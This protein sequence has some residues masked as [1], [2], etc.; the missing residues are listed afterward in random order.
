MVMRIISQRLKDKRK[1]TGLS[2]EQLAEK[3]GISTSYLAYIEMGR[4]KPTLETLQKLAAALHIPMS[5][6]VKAPK[7]GEHA[8]AGDGVGG[9]SRAFERLIRGE[10]PKKVA[11]ILSI[12]ERILKLRR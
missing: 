2:L 1:E 7:D 9:A 3:A 11:E 6:L 10:P 12:L 8:P 5:E 4:R